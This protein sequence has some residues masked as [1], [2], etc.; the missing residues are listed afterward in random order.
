M[1]MGLKKTRAKILELIRARVEE[2]GTSN[3]VE[4]MRIK[5]ESL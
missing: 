5:G 3:G 1:S 2:A 4:I